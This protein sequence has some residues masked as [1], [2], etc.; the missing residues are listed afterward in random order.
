MFNLFNS[1][2]TIRLSIF[3]W[4]CLWTLKFNLFHWSCPKY[5]CELF[6]VSSYYPLTIWD[7]GCNLSFLIFLVYFF[8]QCFV[9]L[10]SLVISLSTLLIIKEPTFGFTDFHYGLFVSNYWFLVFIFSSYMFWV[11]SLF[12]TSLFLKIIYFSEIFL[13]F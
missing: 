5:L 12:C 10:I 13:I 8:S 6:I 1:C 9:L 7:L 2:S 3:S 4:M 11:I